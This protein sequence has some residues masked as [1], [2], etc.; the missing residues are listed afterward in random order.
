MLKV[1]VSKVKLD[2]EAHLR[3]WLAELMDR[4]EEVRETFR[5]ETV[6]HEQAFI[7]DGIQG[8]L[9]LYVMEAGDHERARAAFRASTLP[10]DAEHKLVMEEVLEGSLDIS[11]LYDCAVDEANEAG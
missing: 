1:V 8:P 4:R 6:R 7:L 9:L 10:I 11:P 5:Q 2:K 3:S